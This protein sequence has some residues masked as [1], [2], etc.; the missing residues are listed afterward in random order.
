MKPI[1]ALALLLLAGCASS[2]SLRAGVSSEGEVRRAM[3]PPALEIA[4]A[5]GSRQLAYPTGP[6]GTQTYMVQVGKDGLFQGVQPVLKE[7][8]FYRIQPGSTRDDVLRLI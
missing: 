7:E 3:G 2:D 6:L 5:D 4:Q 1:V 8:N